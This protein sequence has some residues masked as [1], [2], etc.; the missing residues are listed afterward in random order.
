MNSKSACRIIAPAIV[1]MLAVA[2]AAA[3]ES[4]GQAQQVQQASPAAGQGQANPLSG[5]TTNV[6][7]NEPEAPRA[8]GDAARLDEWQ[9]ELIRQVTDYFNSIKHLEGRFKQI[10]PNN[11]VVVGKF[12]VRKPGLL[13]FDYAPPSRLRVVSDGEYLSIED[14]DLNTVDQYPL[15]KTPFRL[16][17]S[18]NVD[19]ATE[20]TILD[21]SRSDSVASITLEDKADGSRGRLQLFFSLPDLELKEWVI[22]DPQGLDTRI[23]LADLVTGNKIKKEFFSSTAL[24]LDHMSGQ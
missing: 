6:A 13:R 18:E 11:Q 5:W 3:I 14:H 7:P 15:D 10:N 19:L 21:V 8:P 17:L 1:A 16:L 24:E 22:T 23:Q 12:Y 2:P 4:W 20:A 9:A